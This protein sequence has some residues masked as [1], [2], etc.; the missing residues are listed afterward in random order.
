M[1]RKQRRAAEKRRKKKDPTQLMADKVKL[2]GEMPSECNVCQKNFDKKD[3]NMSLTWRVV[4]RK[5]VVRLF[6]PECIQ[7]TQEVI[8]EIAK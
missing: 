1:N 3:K 7:K 8:N 2:F 5:E 4:Q 6:C